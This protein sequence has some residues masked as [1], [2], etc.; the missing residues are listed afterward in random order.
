[1]SAPPGHASTPPKDN[2]MSS[3]KRKGTQHLKPKQRETVHVLVIWD[4]DGY[5]IGSINTSAAQ[6]ERS[7][8]AA[9]N[10]LLAGWASKEIEL[11]KDQFLHAKNV[12]M[13]PVMTEELDSELNTFETRDPGAPTD[14]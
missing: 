3:S 7:K 6:L 4:G 9:E 13:K 11:N 10:A 14:V 2:S 8:K 12:S 5:G 1:M